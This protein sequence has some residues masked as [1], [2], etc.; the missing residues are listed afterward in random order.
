MPE[1]LPTPRKRLKQ[2]EKEKIK[3]RYFADNDEN[4]YEFGYTFK[5]EK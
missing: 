4:A 1:E 3:H 5:G 2:L